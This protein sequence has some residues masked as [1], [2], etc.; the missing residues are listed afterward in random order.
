MR[1]RWAEG[2]TWL[3]ELLALRAAQKPSSERAAALAVAGQLAIDQNDFGEAEALLIEGQHLAEHL[4]DE[5]TRAL[6]LYNRA[7]TA[8]VRGDSSI[9]LSLF[10]QSLYVYQRLHD[11]WSVAMTLQSIASV[12]FEMGDVERAE[13][14]TKVALTLFRE[15]G[16]LWGVGR[17]MALLGRTA[18]HRADHPS[19]RSFLTEALSIQRKQ[20]DGQGMTWSKLYLSRT[21]LAQGELAEARQLL[22]ESLTRALELG[23]RLTVVRGLELVAAT[24]VGALPSAAVLLLVAAGVLREALDSTPFPYE[25]QR[26]ERCLS[27][28]RAALDDT[29]FQSASRVGQQIGL[30]PVI[31]EALRAFSS[32]TLPPP[33]SV[34]Q[35]TSRKRVKDEQ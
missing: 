33:E 20:V 17:A 32:L 2:R 25:R 4:G 13:E 30:E 8:R 24:T 23:D 11:G 21:A 15:Q 18:Q 34:G 35:V 1:G 19:A 22:E 14:L 6:C 3:G 9:A 7:G 31:A 16:H 29:A 12:T 28:A 27:A 5:H 10:E 26:L